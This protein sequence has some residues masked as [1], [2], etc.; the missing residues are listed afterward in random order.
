MQSRQSVSS[1]NRRQLVSIAKLL[2]FSCDVRKMVQSVYNRQ[3]A[4]ARAPSCLVCVGRGAGR[5][6]V[7]VEVKRETKPGDNVA[8]TPDRVP[9]GIAPKRC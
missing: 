8:N 4:R 9:G 3:D 7:F 2:S 1:P 5:G 6:V